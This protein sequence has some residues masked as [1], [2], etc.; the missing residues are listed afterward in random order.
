MLPRNQCILVYVVVPWTC[1]ILFLVDCWVGLSSFVDILRFLYGVFLFFFK[2]NWAQRHEFKHVCYISLVFFRFCLRMDMCV[3]V[4]VYSNGCVGNFA[5]IH[6]TWWV[7]YFNPES[8]IK[9]FFNLTR[10]ARRYIPAALL[11]V[12]MTS[13][14]V[15]DYM[16][17]LKK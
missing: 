15:N 6:P 9:V 4:R 8:A 13:F 3:C 17:K 12:F 16:T 2:F 14:N 1:R 5:H 10:N 11:Q 7:C